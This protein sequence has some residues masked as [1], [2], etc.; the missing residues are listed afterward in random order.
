MFKFRIITSR[1]HQCVDLAQNNRETSE[2]LIS[3][4]L[5]NLSIELMITIQGAKGKPLDGENPLSNE[6]ALPKAFRPYGENYDASNIRL[7]VCVS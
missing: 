5:I 3:R 6:S 4:L 1:G 7:S 2:L